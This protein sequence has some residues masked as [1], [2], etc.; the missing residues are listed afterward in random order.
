MT[1]FFKPP[2]SPSPVIVIG[3]EWD[4][5]LLVGPCFGLLYVLPAPDDKWVGGIDV[6]IIRRGKPKFSGWI[7]QQ[8]PTL[9]TTLG[10]SP[11]L[12]ELS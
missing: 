11:S 12:S 10:L 5:S 9:F 2:P 8:S 1:Q 6:M 4:W 3:A 7:L